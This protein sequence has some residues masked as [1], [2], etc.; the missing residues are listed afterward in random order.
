M[1][2]VGRGITQGR[3]VAES[4]DRML[5]LITDQ[6]LP[7]APNQIRSIHKTI[8]EEASSRKVTPRALI[9]ENEGGEVVYDAIFKRF[10][11]TDE[12]EA[13]LTHFDP[14]FVVMKSFAGNWRT[15]GLTQKLTGEVKVIPI[16]TKIVEGLY[17]KARFTW[18]PTFQIQEKIESPTF[19]ALRG[20]T[21]REINPEL[22]AAYQELMKMREF[23]HLE[24]V[25]YLNI[26]GDAM[27]KKFM[28]K[29]TPIG[30]SLS[31]FV[32]IQQDKEAARAIQILYEHGDEFKEAVESIDPRLYAAMRDTYGTSDPRAIA[33]AFLT[34]RMRLTKNIDEAMAAIGPTPAWAAGSTEG[35]MVWQAYKDSFRHVSIQAFKT[36]FFNP[37][38]GWL[39]RTL[40]HPYLGLYPL[41]YMW[42]KVLPEFA[43]FLLVRPFGKNV[44][45][46]GLAN[47]ERVQQA[48]L[49][50]L[51]DD[52]EFSKWIASHEESIYFANLLFP[53]NPTNLTVNAP[54][55]LRH[56]SEDMAAGRPITVETVTREIADSGEYALAGGVKDLS[57]GAKVLGDVGAMGLDAIGSDIFAN[58]DK[59]AREYDGMFPTR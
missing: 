30:R 9:G 27:V 1:D 49:G 46:V 57:Q 11:S 21:R 20:V 23:E 45:L 12:Y 50:A 24:A 51:A 10:L 31:R 43:R 59:A 13:M 34:E 37:R 26:A 18:R 3:I 54:A 53:G 32:N 7:I 22:R 44:P 6:G 48:Y 25:E 5:R 28:G 35:E 38:R 8:L 33:D 14:T 42:G 19:N 4:R 2:A 47:L 16:V 52:P 40:N 39:E 15:V 58:L 56:T 29:N 41:S 55:W 36:H 17:P